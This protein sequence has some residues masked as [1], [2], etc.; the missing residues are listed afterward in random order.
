VCISL[1]YVAAAPARLVAAPDR[2]LY[3]PQREGMRRA[4]SLHSAER[5]Y[6]SSQTVPRLFRFIH[7]IPLMKVVMACFNT[8][9]IYRQSPT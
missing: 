6:M 1:R 3:A 5:D 2:L 8:R 9:T 7:Q 4:T